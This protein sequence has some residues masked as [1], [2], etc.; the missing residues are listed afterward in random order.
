MDQEL[1]NCNKLW[2]K[3]NYNRTEVCVTIKKYIISKPPF[4]QIWLF[5]EKESITM[6]QKAY[7]NYT[8]SELK[9]LSQ[10]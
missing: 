2:D 4:I 8:L 9:E 5:N 6:K 10:I 1:A 3:A 7:V